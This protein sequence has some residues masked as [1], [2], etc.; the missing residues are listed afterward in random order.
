MSL[1]YNLSERWLL[2]YGVD[3]N[4]RDEL[5]KTALYWSRYYNYRRISA[6]IRAF[7]GTL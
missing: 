4:A 5:G 3:P 6:M 2:K 1:F 7:G